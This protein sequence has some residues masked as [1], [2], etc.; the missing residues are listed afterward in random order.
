MEIILEYIYIGSIKEKSLTKDNIIESLKPFIINI[1]LLL[2]IKLLLNIKNK[3]KKKTL[4][5]SA[6]FNKKYAVK[7]TRMLNESNSVNIR[8]LTEKFK[9]C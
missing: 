2:S 8:R 4:S 7:F 1:K 5:H 6:R 3:F 9:Y